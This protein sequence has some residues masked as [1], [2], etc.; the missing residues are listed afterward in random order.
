MSSNITAANQPITTDLP[1]AQCEYNLKT[2][3]PTQSCPECGYPVN[4]TLDHRQLTIN[5]ITSRLSTF[6]TLIVTLGVILF[7][8][9]TH[10]LLLM[11]ISLPDI[12]G[13]PAFG[14]IL[15][16]FAA[17]YYC[18]FS[19]FGIVLSLT[20]LPFFI[21]NIYYTQLTKP[22][23]P[24]L[25]RIKSRTLTRIFLFL[26]YFTL[27]FGYYYLFGF[28]H[29]RARARF[30]SVC[31]FLYNIFPFVAF[32]YAAAFFR[33]TSHITA[34]LSLLK[35]TRIAK[36]TSRV[37]MIYLPMTLIGSIYL[38]SHWT[39]G[40]Q[41]FRI[42]NVIIFLYIFLNFTWSNTCLLFALITLKK[43]RTTAKPYE[44]S[45]DQDHVY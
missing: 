13:I 44:V 6:D 3:S 22:H 18:S 11:T 43:I 14:G 24:N 20:L 19:L 39:L 4:Q 5:W 17:L 21:T 30:Y 2:L 9:S 37:S 32:L 28:T 31:L 12:F 34:S 16:T 29:I 25:I 7:C 33:Y 40:K 26:A 36:L 41:P 1:C 35:Q 27:F 23:P 42:N 45:N 15:E 8:L 38:L 10:Q